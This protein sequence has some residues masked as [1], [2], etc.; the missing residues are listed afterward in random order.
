MTVDNLRRNIYNKIQRIKCSVTR[1]IRA[2]LICYRAEVKIGVKFMAIDFLLNQELLN[3][4]TGLT[5][6]VTEIGVGMQDGQELPKL[7][8]RYSDGAVKYVFYPKSFICAKPFRAVDSGIQA[9]VE[10]DLAQ[11][12]QAEEAARLAE[13]QRRAEAQADNE[14]KVSEQKNELG[15]NPVNYKNFCEYVEYL[16]KKRDPLTAGYV[17]R[18]GRTNSTYWIYVTMADWFFEWEN[19]KINI[20]MEAHLDGDFHHPLVHMEVVYDG[21][22]VNKFET[23]SDNRLKANIGEAQTERYAAFRE[24]MRDLFSV[25]STGTLMQLTVCRPS[26]DGVTCEEYF[27]NY[28]KKIKELNKLFKTRKF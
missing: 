17:Y 11:L 27:E 12:R 22:T 9:M 6:I 4:K 15:R 8:L 3:S 28:M 7:T 5:A 14:R 16:F 26:V 24:K 25:Y 23:Y 21:N 13:E 10:Q 18:I 2:A 19:R 20:H 1:I